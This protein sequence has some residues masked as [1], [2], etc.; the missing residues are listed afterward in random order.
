MKEISLNKGRVALVDDNMFDYLNQWKWYAWKW[1]YSFYAIRNIPATNSQPRTSVKMHRI[2]MQ[3]DDRKT[4]IDHIDQNGLNNQIN[5][6]RTCSRS[7]NMA[8]RKSR[9]NSTSKYLGVSFNKQK[10]KWVA[11]IGKNGKIYHIG[12]FYSEKEAAQAYNLKANEVHGAF[13]NINNV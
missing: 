7:Q 1:G 12:V 5:N 3:I 11:Q 9:K 2:I 6:L 8:N 4:H 10:N 13:A